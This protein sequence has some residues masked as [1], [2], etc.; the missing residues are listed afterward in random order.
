ME[1]ILVYV[2]IFILYDHVKFYFSYM[3]RSIFKKQQNYTTILQ[4]KIPKCVC[5]LRETDQVTFLQTK[6]IGYRR[7]SSLRLLNCH[8]HAWP[9]VI[10]FLRDLVWESQC[11]QS[12]HVETSKRHLVNFHYLLTIQI[13]MAGL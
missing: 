6:L 11:L 12:S 5:P 1:I 8:D 9:D 2:I 4:I 7:A 13:I 10:N 3:L